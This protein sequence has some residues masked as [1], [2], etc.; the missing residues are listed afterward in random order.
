MRPTRHAKITLPGTKE[1]KNDAV[2]VLC[3]WNPFKDEAPHEKTTHQ[4][5]AKE[6]ADSQRLK[7]RVC[8]VK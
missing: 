8:V 4:E 7:R 2:A 1:S 6:E 3:A 5:V